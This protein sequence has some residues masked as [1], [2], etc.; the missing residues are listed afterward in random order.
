[1]SRSRPA[2]FRPQLEQLEG[3][4]VPTNISRL[5]DAAGQSHLFVV[6]GAGSLTR[7]DPGGATLWFAGGNRFNVQYPQV[8]WAQA[9]LDP[10]GQ[11]GVNVLLD[12]GPPGGLHWIVYDS[13]GSHDEGIAND[14]RSVSTAFD[15]AGQKTLDIIRSGVWYQF[16]STGGHRMGPVN[17][18][19]NIMLNYHDFASTAISRTGARVTDV[20]ESW[21]MGSGPPF[22]TVTYEI[23]PPGQP[24]VI[25][26][27]AGSVWTF[28]FMPSFDATGVLGH[29]YLEEII[30]VSHQMPTRTSWIY[31]PAPGVSYDMG[32]I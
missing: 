24:V 10:A 17:T 7:Y 23:Q 4:L 3:R 20:E 6:Q 11:L 21:S 25:G 29:D 8:Q 14:L 19:P 1:M 12:F 27:I 22:T 26:S 15:P 16:D 31:A 30:D 28:G 18:D 13:A 9:Y 32:N 2:S 5:I